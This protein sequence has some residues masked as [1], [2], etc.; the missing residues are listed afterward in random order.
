MDRAHAR[1]GIEERAVASLA[2]IEEPANLFTRPEHVVVDWT[3]SLSDQR[4]P[5]AVAQR[6]L[7]NQLLAAFAAPAFAVYRLVA[8]DTYLAFLGAMLPVVVKL[9]FVD[10][11]HDLAA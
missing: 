11:A 3:G 5:F 4:F 8:L 7:D 10:A 2:V 1:L 6:D 9:V